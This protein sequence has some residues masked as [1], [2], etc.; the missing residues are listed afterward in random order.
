MP[1]RPSILLPVLVVLGL[2]GVSISAADWTYRSGRSIPGEPAAFDGAEK[3]VT[4]RDRVSERETEVPA[5]ELSLSSRQRLLFSPVF[6]KSKREPPYWHGKSA[7]LLIV[8]LALPAIVLGLAF[9]FAGWFFTRKMNP[10]LAVTA[11]FGSWAIIG[12]LAVCYAFLL[13]RLD[14]GIKIIL[15]GVTVALSVTPLYLSAV[16]GCS[17]WK[18]HLILLAHLFA[19]GFILATGVAAIELVGGMNV[20]EA[21][22]EAVVFEPLGLTAAM[23]SPPPPDR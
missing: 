12:I 1:F 15:V 20:I 14:G 22:W 5:G 8:A 18:G 21:W 2:T 4:F 7:D 11:F 9:W 17:Y 6:L 23:E 19:G 16:Y 10:L 3:R 13:I